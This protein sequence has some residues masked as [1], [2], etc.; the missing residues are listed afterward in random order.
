MNAICFKKDY[1]K[2]IF[3]ITK[4]MFPIYPSHG[5]ENSCLAGDFFLFEKKPISFEPVALIF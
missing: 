1:V 3:M 2:N 5:F 4:V